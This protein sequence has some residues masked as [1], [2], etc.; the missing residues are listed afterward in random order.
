[1]LLLSLMTFSVN[2]DVTDIVSDKKWIHGSANCDLNTDP[3]IDQLRVNN[4]TF[5]LRQNK[6][7]NVEAPF[8]YVLF[9]QHTVFIQDTGATEDPDK[10]PIYKTIQQLVDNW[11]DENS[12]SK[13]D[14]LVTH[15]HSHLDHRAGDA[16]FRNKADVIL[17]EANEDAII[18]Y[19]NFANWPDGETVIDL[20]NRKLT[21]FPIPGHHDESIAVYDTQTRWLLTGDTFYPGRLYIKDWKQ[22]KNSIRKLLVF[23]EEHQVSALMGTHIEMTSTARIDYTFGTTFQPEEARLPLMASDLSLLN[24]TLEEMGDDAN[25]KILDKFIIAPV[26]IIQRVLGTVLGWIFA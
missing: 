15:S 9:G 11:K 23:V 12:I 10:F 21:V 19:F 14:I 16:Q 2:A 20:G 5:I 24:K 8:I 3:A 26:G 25:D 7:I 1:M 22:F 13:M 4:D 18:E 6:C 17:I